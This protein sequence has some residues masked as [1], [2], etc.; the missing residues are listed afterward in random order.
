M[1]RAEVQL[2][3]AFS[4]RVDELTPRH[5]LIRANCARTFNLLCLL[6][7]C[8]AWQSSLH[9]ALYADV[10]GDGYTDQ[11]SL[12]GYTVVVF[13][14]HTGLTSRHEHQNLVALSISYFA[15]TDGVPGE[16]IIL[17]LTQSYTLARIV[18]VIHVRTG[19]RNTYE[20]PDIGG[21]SISDV[22]DTDGIAGD[23]IIILYTKAY[24][25]A[26]AVDVIHDTTRSRNT[27]D[28]GVVAR[29][30]INIANYD[31]L[32]G[33]EICAHW[34]I[35]ANSGDNLIVD[36][37][38]TIEAGC[39][40][41]PPPRISVAPSSQDFGSIK[42][43]NTV[44]RN[45]TVQNTGGGN[46]SGSAS[47]PAPYS[48]VSGASY[49][50]GAGAS[51]TVTL[52]YSPTAAGTHNQAVS[53]TGGGGATR[54]VTGSAYLAPAILVTPPSFDFGQVEV[55]SINTRSFTVQ[56]TGGGTLS[57]SANV[58][59]PFSIISGGTYN[60]TAGQSNLVVVQYRPTIA[61]AH[62]NN[63]TFTGATGATRPVIGQAFS[64]STDSDGDGMCDWAEIVAG[65]SPS[66][67]QS[68][69]KLSFP[70]TGPRPPTGNGLIL[71]WPSASNRFYYVDRSTNLTVG[72]NQS[73]ATNLPATPPMN[74]HTDTTANA[75]VP[76]FY[77]VR[78]EREGV[79]PF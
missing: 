44:D 16:E 18:E 7:V 38:R 6:L 41:A 11:I 15:D 9:A 20:Y 52:L 75:G 50:L 35:G 36:R 54:P 71:Q 8:L 22:V 68:C 70:A 1:K 21:L 46:L 76:Y 47:V 5:R 51:H 4:H 24:T 63:V 56:N 23:E 57:G 31:G 2:P 78:V 29:L 55:G 58:A 43:G 12:S 32:D 30:S 10:D 62:N 69:F 61:G 3:D 53:F 73:V 37:T 79:T 77:K 49:N 64:S 27:Y 19:A 72:F 67:S 39:N 17:L 74:T 26:K 33:A 66:D 59:T 48:I 65:T 60:V 34:W 28:F 14:P 40:V 13:H 42:V 25:T 45:F